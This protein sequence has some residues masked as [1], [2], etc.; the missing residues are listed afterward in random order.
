MKLAEALVQVK[1]LKG[2]VADLNR[3]IQNDAVFDQ[4]DEG[5]E[6]PDT[7]LLIEELITLTR[8]LGGL[9][10][11]V[12][13]TNAQ[14]GLVDK[15]NEMAQLRSLVAQL[16]GLT[17]HKQ[18]TTKLRRIDFGE[19]HVKMQVHATYNVE[20]VASRVEEMRNRIRKLDLELQRLNWEVDLVD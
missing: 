2:K 14:Y 8:N 16:E 7:S 1:D 9:K 5:Q 12:A 20:E 3:R 13:R 15:I 10:T 11:R 18:S 17:N 19:P 4:V 6:V